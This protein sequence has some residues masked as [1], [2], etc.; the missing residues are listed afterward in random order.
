MQQ[1]CQE[2]FWKDLLWFSKS[3]HFFSLS[4]RF[5]KYNGEKV[6]RNHRAAQG[7]RHITVLCRICTSHIYGPM[8]SFLYMC[9]HVRAHVCVCVFMC[10]CVCG[11][12]RACVCG[13]MHRFSPVPTNFIAKDQMFPTSASREKRSSVSSHLGTPG[14]TLCRTASA[15]GS[16]LV[17]CTHSNPFL[18]K[19]LTLAPLIERAASTLISCL[20]QPLCPHS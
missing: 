6:G 9:M 7:L 17:T 5:E 11:C 20:A 3:L 14:G 16:S 10:A 1:N 15:P 13:G 18:Q 19:V 12:M 8:D 4:L 2:I